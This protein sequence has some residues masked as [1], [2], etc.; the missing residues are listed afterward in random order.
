[1]D[2]EKFQN[3][4]RFSALCE[5]FTHRSAC[6][7]RRRV[8]GCRTMDTRGFIFSCRET[9]ELTS[10]FLS[11]FFF[12]ADFILKKCIE[13]FKSLMPYPRSSILDPA[14]PG[15]PR[16]VQGNLKTIVY[17]NLPTPTNTSPSILTT[18]FAIKSL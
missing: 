14:F 3:C 1:M 6:K 18:L 12:I 9:L 13:Y 2:K 15:N 10:L 11:I 7:Q 8:S 4:N 16:G 5:Q 17:K